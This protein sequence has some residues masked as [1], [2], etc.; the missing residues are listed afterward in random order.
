MAKDKQ[1]ATGGDKKS[2]EESFGSRPGS[3]SIAGGT[4]TKFG[5]TQRDEVWPPSPVSVDVK[6]GYPKGF[7]NETKSVKGMTGKK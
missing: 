5:Y 2:R 4:M 7:Q 3:V 6:S 1:V